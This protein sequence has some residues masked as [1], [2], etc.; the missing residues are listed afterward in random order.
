MFYSYPAILECQLIVAIMNLTL[1]SN[2]FARFLLFSP[3]I[4]IIQSTIDFANPRRDLVSG[5]RARTIGAW[6]TR[7]RVKSAS[8]I[9]VRDVRAVAGQMVDTLGIS[10]GLGRTRP[11]IKNAPSHAIENQLRRPKR[12]ML[13]SG[14]QAEGDLP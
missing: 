9:S 8:E 7:E 1:H 6:L 12:S 13:L 4:A 3:S 2:W 5:T 11:I 14:R 10:S